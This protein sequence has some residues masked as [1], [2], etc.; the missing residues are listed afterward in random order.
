[1]IAFDLLDYMLYVVGKSNIMCRF[2][3]DTFEENSKTTIGVAFATK[4]I[5][6]DPSDSCD[7][8]KKE[9]KKNVKLQVWDTGNQS[10]FLP[11]SQQ[12][13]FLLVVVSFYFPT[14]P[15]SAS[16]SPHLSLLVLCVSMKHSA[17]FVHAAAFVALKQMQLMILPLPLPSLPFSLSLP[18]RAVCC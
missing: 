9:G 4:N 11:C 7:E 8:M 10:R 1:M 6:I 16:A 2:T 18:M 13:P 15:A 14:L 17:A 12:H 5:I 3:N